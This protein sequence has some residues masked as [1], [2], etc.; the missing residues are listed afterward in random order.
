MSVFPKLLLADAHAE[1]CE[2][3]LMVYHVEEM[4]IVR[5]AIGSAYM[6]PLNTI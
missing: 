5:V 2:C 4:S 6:D 1:R 3:P